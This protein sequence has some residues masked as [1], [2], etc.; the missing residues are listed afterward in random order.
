MTMPSISIPQQQTGEHCRR[1][2]RRIFPVAL[3]MLLL[4]GLRGMAEFSRTSTWRPPQGTNLL[5][6]KVVTRRHGLIRS[7]SLYLNETGDPSFDM[8]IE[9]NG[10]LVA[11]AHEEAALDALI[12]WFARRGADADELHLNGSLL[13]FPEL[14]VDGRGSGVM[15][16]SF[17][18]TA[19]SSTTNRPTMSAL[20][21]F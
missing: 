21:R 17:P 9:H 14:L 8:T 12:A 6:A 18:P 20:S 2:T 19:S 11:P 3:L 13:R 16:S 15:K 7:R 4:A 5:G 10:L 1:A